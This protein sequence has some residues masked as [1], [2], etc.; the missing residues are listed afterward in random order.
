M[1]EAPTP[2]LMTGIATLLHSL[3]QL[4]LC[5]TFPFYEIS[6]NYAMQWGTY[7]IGDQTGLSCVVV[8]VQGWEKI[9]VVGIVLLYTSKTPDGH[10]SQSNSFP[11]EQRDLQCALFVYDGAFISVVFVTAMAIVSCTIQCR[12]VATELFRVVLRSSDQLG[13]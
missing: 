2:K 1:I 7:H 13:T 5:S 6:R 11:M 4:R 8:R 12:A 3:K 10:F 9:E